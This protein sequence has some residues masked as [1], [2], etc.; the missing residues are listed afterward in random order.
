[1]K[2][3]IAYDETVGIMNSFPHMFNLGNNFEFKGIADQALR[4]NDHNVSIRCPFRHFSHVGASGFRA[5]N[6]A[7]QCRRDKKCYAE[8]V[9]RHVWFQTLLKAELLRRIFMSKMSYAKPERSVDAILTRQFDFWA[10]VLD[11]GLTII[12]AVF[13]T[14]V[15][16]LRIIVDEF[17]RLGGS[18]SVAVAEFIAI[19]CVLFWFY[20]LIK[21]TIAFYRWMQ[22][23]YT[24]KSEIVVGSNKFVQKRVIGNTTVYEFL[25]NGELVAIPLDNIEKNTEVAEMSMPGSELYPS[26]SRQIGAVLISSSTTELAVLGCFFRIDDYLITAKHVAN[27]AFSSISDVYLTNTVTSRGKSSYKVNL[28][29]W[30]APKAL[31]DIDDNDVK[32]DLDLFVK[33]LT[34]A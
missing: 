11:A 17:Y 7:N 15:S 32:T 23:E 10:T 8:V 29:A 18:N 34:P 2:R 25:V 21:F 26:S 33:K 27:A 16:T 13:G 1:M 12:C 6:I 24:L 4:Y 19:I 9:L 14:A 20:G 28:G 3:A 31:F 30:P 5:L 22:P